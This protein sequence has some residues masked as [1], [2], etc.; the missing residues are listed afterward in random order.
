L[1]GSFSK[2]FPGHAQPCKSLCVPAFIPKDKGRLSE[3]T[4]EAKPKPWLEEW[5]R[6]LRKGWSGGMEGTSLS[7]GGASGSELIASG[8]ASSG[9]AGRACVA[10]NERGR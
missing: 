2:L 8:R 4:A 9:F 7:A 6:E 1:A 3:D 10:A 5:M